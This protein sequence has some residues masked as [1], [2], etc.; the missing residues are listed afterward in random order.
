MKIGE[1]LSFASRRLATNP[2]AISL[3]NEVEGKATKL[4]QAFRNLGAFKTY[5][6]ATAG[7][8]AHCGYGS[9]PDA[10]PID[11]CFNAAKSAVL[12]PILPPVMAGLV[13][14]TAIRPGLVARVAV[15]QFPRHDQD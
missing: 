12:L 3:K 13:V 8:G 1:F 9:D 4:F 7:L 5:L 6:Y 2:K 15:R 11:K 10:H 14:C